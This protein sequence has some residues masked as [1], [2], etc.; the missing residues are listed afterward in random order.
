MVDIEHL[1][2]ERP[3]EKMEHQVSEEEFNDLKDKIVRAWEEYKLLQREY[4]K[5]TGKEMQWL[6]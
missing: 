5:L 1:K 4:M 3:G 6:K 2:D